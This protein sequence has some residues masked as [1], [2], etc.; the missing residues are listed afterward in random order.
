M[1]KP[2]A[3]RGSLLTMIPAPGRAR[4]GIKEQGRPEQAKG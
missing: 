4:H 2:L 1:R 3:D